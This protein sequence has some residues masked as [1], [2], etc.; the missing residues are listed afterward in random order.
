MR[1]LVEGLFVAFIL[2]ESSGACEVISFSHSNFF[3]NRFDEKC[4]I[5]A[6][7]LGMKN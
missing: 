2:E 3:K 4:K 1:R 7:R 5:F 6:S